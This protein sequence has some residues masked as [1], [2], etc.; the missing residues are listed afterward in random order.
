MA[1]NSDFDINKHDLSKFIHPDSVQKLELHQN[2]TSTI[3]KAMPQ[4]N[5]QYS[6]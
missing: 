6:S 3:N 2:S 4:L 5:P 1:A